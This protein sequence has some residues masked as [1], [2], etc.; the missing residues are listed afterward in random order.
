MRHLSLLALA[1]FAVARALAAEEEALDREV[2][3]IDGG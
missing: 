3:G 1:G 2:R